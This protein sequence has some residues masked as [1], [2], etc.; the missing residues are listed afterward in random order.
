MFKRSRIRKN[1]KPTSWER[2]DQL[3][4]IMATDELYDEYLDTKTELQIG[5]EL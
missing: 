4:C 3:M 1:R 2:L 5:V